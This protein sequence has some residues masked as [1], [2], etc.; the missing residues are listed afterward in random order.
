MPSR[1]TH[2]TSRAWGGA[3]RRTRG[4]RRTCLSNPLFLP[5]LT[6]AAPPELRGDI[7]L[8]KRGFLSDAGSN[9]PEME[10]RFYSQHDGTPSYTAVPTE[11][12]MDDLKRRLKSLALDERSLERYLDV[13]GRTCEVMTSEYT[14]KAREHL[15]ERRMK[16]E[17]D[18]REALEALREDQFR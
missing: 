7:Y 12:Y 17:A 5:Y 18:V 15:K 6:D 8:I 13:Q 1:R 3:P 11:W 16:V 4:T 9:T 2:D 10:R 14:K